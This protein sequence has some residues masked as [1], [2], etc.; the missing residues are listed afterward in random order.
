[1]LKMHHDLQFFVKFTRL[2]AMMMFRE[3]IAFIFSFEPNVSSTNCKNER[4][5]K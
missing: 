1:M 2:E 3:Q 5:D 4:G